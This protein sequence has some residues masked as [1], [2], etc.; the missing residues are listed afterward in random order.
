MQTGKSSSKQMEYE[1][2]KTRGVAQPLKPNPEEGRRFM[3]NAIV[4]NFQIVNQK[5]GQLQWGC[6]EGN[7]EDGFHKNY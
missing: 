6:V 5:D 2:N 1:E 4:P 7:N 3:L